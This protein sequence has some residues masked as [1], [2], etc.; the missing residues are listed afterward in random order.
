[1]TAPRVSIAM[2]T[3]N[4]ARFLTEQLESIANQT[5]APLELIICD[6]GST[7]TTSQVAEAFA[8]RANFRVQVHVNASRLGYVRNFR[9]AASLCSGELISFCDQDDWWLPERLEVCSKCFQDPGLQLLY[10]NA[11]LVDET[12]HRS[13][14]LYDAESERAAL[15][16]APMAPWNHSYGLVQ[17]FR[18]SLRQLDDLWDHSLNHIWEPMDILAHDQWYFFLAQAVGRVDFLDR[19]LVEYRQHGS[20]QFGAAWV[21]PAVENR[22]LKRF[23]HDGRQD[24]RL[25]KAADARSFILRQVAERMSE[26]APR[27]VNIADHYRKLGQR[28]HR[29]FETYCAPRF[30]TRLR[31][32]F[33]SWYRNDYSDW[34]WG[35]NKWSLVRDLWSGVVHG[36][37]AMD[38]LCSAK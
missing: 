13:G 26:Q 18:S 24:L 6:D 17:I 2:A 7:D 21:R 22:L 27:L 25:A 8:V 12:R 30:G 10:H 33:Y 1:M 16:L 14:L 29:R 32:L 5:I 20:N 23:A 28:N 11:W 4:G 37:R 38:T 3:F 9:K 35:F 34:P 31:S 15:N 36:N 19:P